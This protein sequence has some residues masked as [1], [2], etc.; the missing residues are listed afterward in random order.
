M[1]THTRSVFFIRGDY[2]IVQDAI[3]SATAHEIVSRYQC[4][5]DIQPIMEGTSDVALGSPDDARWLLLSTHASSPGQL[6]IEQACI[7]P[8]YGVQ[9]PAARCAFR[10]GP[11]PNAE[12][13]TALIPF[14]RD[15]HRP[16]V[17]S[18]ETARGQA[19]RI[20]T[21]ENEDVL[22]VADERGGCVED[23]QTDARWMWLRRDPA[24]EEV[25]ELILIDGQRVV[26][27]G[28]VLCD[29]SRRERW[30]HARRVATGWLVQSDNGEQITATL[31][32]GAPLCAASA[33]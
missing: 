28:D 5:A 22:L 2:W 27:N 11:T 31:S 29:W 25:R 21:A 23:I 8:A 19:L 13:L 17:R 16:V 1:A 12:I 7:S 30:L 9:F 20:R 32:V 24:S 3:E 14:S 26:I 33:A 4:A 6:S 15:R 10:V 18:V